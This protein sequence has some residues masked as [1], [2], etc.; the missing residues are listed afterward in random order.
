MKIYHPLQNIKGPA[1]YLL[2]FSDKEIEFGSASFGSTGTDRPGEGE[3]EYALYPADDLS[4]IEL[5]E[6]SFI[7]EAFQLTVHQVH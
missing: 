1:L 3:E 5:S 7:L 6:L 2:K 4:L